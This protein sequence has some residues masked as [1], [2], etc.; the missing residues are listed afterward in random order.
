MS[1]NHFYR[2]KR[3]QG[4]I[5]FV[6]VACLALFLSV[7]IA[8][9]FYANQQAISM[10]FQ[11]EASSGGRAAY[12]SSQTTRGSTDEAPP[13]A[14]DLFNFA[15][16][17][18]IYDIATPTGGGQPVFSAMYGHSLARAMYGWNGQAG[19]NSTAY[20]GFGRTRAASTTINYAVPGAMVPE[21]ES[22]SYVAK[23]APYTYPDEN[24]CYLAA[25]QAATGKVLVPSFHRPW[26][27]GSVYGF[28]NPGNPGGT[29]NPAKLATQSTMLR[30]IPAP[31]SAFPLP[32]QNSDGTYGDVENLE[33]KVG[34]PQ[35]D[36]M[37]IDLD[38]PV[39][40]WRGRY[41]KPM[42]AFLVVDLDGRINVNVAGNNKGPGQ[43]SNQGWGTWEMNPNAV[44][45]ASQG[46]QALVGIANNGLQRYYKQTT[47]PTQ[48]FSLDG[49]AANIGLAT[50]LGSPP[51][52][53]RVNYGSSG[54][55]P[56]TYPLQ[57]YYTAPNY[58]T[59]N[60]RN[61][62]TSELTGHPSLYNPYFT[63]R[64]KAPK[65][66]WT[67][68]YDQSYGPEEMF[69]LNAMENAD[70]VDAARSDLALE[71]TM[72]NSTVSQPNTLSNP[73]NRLLFTTISNDL[74]TPG[75][76]PWVSTSSTAPSGYLQAAAAAGSVPPLPS[77]SAM[78]SPTT[79][80]PPTGSEFDANWRSTLAA[81]LSSIDLNRKLTDYRTD[82]TKPFEA[83]VNGTF[84]GAGANIVNGKTIFATAQA[85][86][87]RLAQDIFDR[88]CATT[89]ANVNITASHTIPTTITVGTPAYDALRR[90]AQIA[91]NIVDYIDN[92]DYITPFNWNPAYSNMTQSSN[93]QNGWV[94]G[95]ELPRLVI[96]EV[97]ANWDND[98]SPN[99]PNGPDPHMVPNPNAVPPMV[100]A[101]TNQYKVGVWAELC[102]PLTPP[103]A[104]ANVTDANYPNLSFG[105]GAALALPAVGGNP[106]VNVYQM[107]ITKTANTGLGSAS[108]TNGA[109]DS[110]Q[111]V[112]VAQ[113][114]DPS[115]NPQNPFNDG[116][117]N[118][119]GKPY[120]GVVKPSN[121][122]QGQIPPNAQAQPSN[123][124][125]YLVG[126]N[127]AQGTAFLPGNDQPNPV[128]ISYVAS[129]MG[130]S[131]PNSTTNPLVV[132]ATGSNAPSTLLLQRLLC[133]YMPSSA[134]NPYVTV[135]Y[136]VFDPNQ[137]I[138]DHRQW[139]S[140]GEPQPAN[141]PPGT[142][143]KR[144]TYDKQSSWGRKQPYGGLAAPNSSQ[145]KAQI[146]TPT[147]PAAKT[148]P[149]DDSNTWINHT[150]CRQ[151]NPTTP[152]NTFDWLTHLD[153]TLI[154]P[155][156]LFCVS[157]WPPHQLTQ[158]FVNANQIAQSHMANWNNTGTYAGGNGANNALLY[159]SLSLLDVRNRTLGL[160]FGGRIPGKVNINTVFD[161]NNASTP[162]W[163]LNAICNAPAAAGQPSS[164]STGNLFT[165]TTNVNTAW[166]T[167][168]STRSPTLLGPITSI[169]PNSA[170][171]TPLN[172][173]PFLPP[174][175][176]VLTGADPNYPSNEGI[177][178]IGRTILTSFT[179]TNANT[180]NHPYLQ[181]ELLTKI[182]NNLTTRSNC[183]AVYCTIGYFEVTNPGPYS[184]TN[185]PV[186]GGELGSNDGSNIRHKFFAIVDR[187][188][189]AIDQ[190]TTPKTLQGPRPIFLSYEPVQQT[191]EPDTTTT[192]TVIVRIPATAATSTG[193]L[194]GIYDG[195]AWTIANGA[196][197]LVD[198]GNRQETATV[199]GAAM[200]PTI[201]SGGVIY[202][203]GGNITL[204]FSGTS[205]F[206]H[207][208]GCI[209]Q[210][211]P[212]QTLLGNPGPQPQFN[213][214]DPRYGGV[215]P[216]VARYNRG[217]GSN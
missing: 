182:Y 95:T 136:V 120:Y 151:N 174:S 89:G 212:G 25:V 155:P 213:F 99:S 106:Q 45:S 217:S 171:T 90:L 114:G 18:L 64:T 184:A 163:T 108:N 48:I 56:L 79:S 216:Y 192:Q 37:W 199:S 187:T 11:R 47:Q 53:S 85:D 168:M 73:N 98:T 142:N 150:F 197:I 38:A 160:G 34:S 61:A 10:R 125:F 214:R 137:T 40:S 51:F 135:D 5:L 124:G 59:A 49:V 202:N 13:Q 4:A 196:Q 1:P 16:G 195:Q 3:R 166:S 91:V 94:F 57:Q 154:S 180:G 178:G 144:Q 210:I 203:G 175:S 126:P 62:N 27:V 68:A 58:V 156:E 165:Q 12:I 169:W 23:N 205:G 200:Q 183:F 93:I 83:I 86:R 145:Y 188:N 143:S 190:T 97:Y 14:T 70:S 111:I 54:A 77:G 204:K 141:T 161:S 32:M 133:P 63:I 55:T 20:N 159:R 42:F 81:A 147:P 74:Q 207:S 9:V 6:V 181:N 158:Q 107:I 130:W 24:N 134:T 110:T 96:N 46:T 138:W 105:G 103:A 123:P 17:Q 167:I 44:F 186:L 117:T 67:F 75:L 8:F 118:N 177:D 29:Q 102:N 164:G 116:S 15:L 211:N 139:T 26:L 113:L 33:G 131:I 122:T 179:N 194:T 146:G 7:G 208:R 115:I 149:T 176:G 206:A 80:P 198:V 78:S 88:L 50:S 92:D 65:P 119:N 43:F 201:T 28:P 153:R 19:Q 21:K 36:S 189:L 132:T 209:M 129:S 140:V 148:P 87:Q 31:G 2:G 157:A 112:T 172:D 162:S 173:K 60:Y 127:N 121:A 82:P 41:Y 185:R 191:P 128:P 22:G 193:G 39:R 101:A 66:N 76:R 71:V 84:N 109:Q 152:S 104:N 170:S 35:F 100:Q 30:P 52:Y 72:L 69:F 215:V